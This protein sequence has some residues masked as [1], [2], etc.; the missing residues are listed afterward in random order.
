MSVIT[1]SQMPNDPA[2]AGDRRGA[3][4][5]LAALGCDGD[6]DL[7]LRELD[8]LG[9]THTCSVTFVGVV[10]PSL[11]VRSCAPLS[12]MTTSES[13]AQ[14]A[15]DAARQLAA[16][17]AAK[18]RTHTLDHLGASSDW[19]ASGLLQ[20]LRLGVYDALIIGSLPHGRR[21]RRRLLAAAE[22]SG[23]AVIAASSARDAQQR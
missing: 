22:A 14:I 4:R 18:A 8:A 21:T 10:R 11:F 5:V 17:A 15:T 12:G 2:V 3:M 16:T 13:I 23:T 19:N 6:A 9:K 20:R 1:G 7:V